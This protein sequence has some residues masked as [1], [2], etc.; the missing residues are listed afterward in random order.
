[1][2]VTPAKVRIELTLRNVKKKDLAKRMGIRPEALSRLI[3]SDETSKEL[4]RAYRILQ[5]WGRP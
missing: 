4:E 5:A 2:N 1:M 3:H